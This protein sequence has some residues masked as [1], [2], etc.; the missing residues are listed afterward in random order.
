MLLIT[1]IRRGF[2][3]IPA[4]VGFCGILGASTIC[5]RV[6]DYADLPLHDARTT[7]VNLGTNKTSVALTGRDGR[8]CVPGLPEGLYSVEIGLAGFLNVRYY[9]IRLAFPTTPDL[10]FRLPFGEITE[11]GLAA[12]AVISGT[13]KRADI[14][15]GSAKICILGLGAEQPITCGTTNELGEYALSLPPGTYRVEVT[16]AGGL[17]YRSKIEVPVP[18]VYRNRIT[19]PGTNATRP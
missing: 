10:Q 12:D 8:A 1:S 7:V 5:V 15:I 4:V 18:G 16:L 9:P 19:L 14:A 13:L 6:K 11:G 3:A 2:G 17:V